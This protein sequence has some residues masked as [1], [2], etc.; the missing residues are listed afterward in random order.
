[1][2]TAAAWG[3]TTWAGSGEAEVG[4]TGQGH[5][6]RQHMEPQTSMPPMGGGEVPTQPQ[7]SRWKKPA[8]PLGTL[9]QGRQLAAAL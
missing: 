6:H 2:L 4:L 5:R 1:M 8:Q 7:P 9:R 3:V